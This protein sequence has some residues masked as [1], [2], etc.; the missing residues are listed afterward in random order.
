[1]KYYQLQEKIGYKFNDIK[2]LEKALILSSYDHENNNQ[3]METLGDAILDFLVAER[4]FFEGGDD[5]VITDRRKEIVSDKALT[6]VS[7]G[8]GLPELLMRGKGDC[9][10][11]KSVPSA[12]E[13]LVCAV[14]LDG[15]MDAARDVVYRTLDFT[16]AREHDYI[17]KV[18][19]Y[20]EKRG[21]TPPEYQKIDGDDGKGMRT[22]LFGVE[23]ECTGYDN[24]QSAKRAVAKCAYDAIIKL[25][26]KG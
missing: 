24:F 13:A 4:L 23:Y 7:R 11:K 26:R 15:G 2:L 21:L 6:P 10:N 1:M 22:V 5:Q 17:S 19:E 12:Y 14:Y 3:A 16:I 25:E 8:L 18:K 9:N 20:F